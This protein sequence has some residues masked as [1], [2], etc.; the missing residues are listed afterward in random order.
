MELAG[1]DTPV[2]DHRRHRRTAEPRG[3]GKHCILGWDGCETVYE[4]HPG[5]SVF[6][7]QERAFPFNLQRSPSHMGYSLAGIRG[8]TAY[9][10]LQ[11]P[12]AGAVSL[13][14]SFEQQL[15]P[16]ADPEHWTVI[17]H[18]VL[19]MR[20]ESCCIQVRHRRVEGSDTRKNQGIHS[21]EIIPAFDRSGLL[22]E[23]F[24]RL[25]Y[26]VE[27]SH[28]VIN[29]ADCGMQLVAP[30]AARSVQ[31]YFEMVPES[32]ALGTAPTTVSTF[33]PLLKTIRVGMLRI[34]Y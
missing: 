16:K 31:R 3:G 14:A 33:W 28:S 1:S 20:D 26:G 34:P 21:D 12:E 7:L 24:H 4:V 22:T 2:P 10:A 19:K 5:L 13:V 32:V 11:H 30:V 27:I 23:S 17:R 8:Q 15:Q 9:M 6:N 18:P 25:I 29:Q